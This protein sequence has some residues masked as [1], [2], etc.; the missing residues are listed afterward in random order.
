MPRVFKPRSTSSNPDHAIEIV[1]E[2]SAHEAMELLAAGWQMVLPRHPLIISDPDIRGG[3]PT[4]RGTRIGAIEIAN[5]ARVDT[6]DD[7]YAQYPSLTPELLAAAI[8]YADDTE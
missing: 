4:L 3:I 1:R 6:H 5:Q 2:C 8:G 7:I